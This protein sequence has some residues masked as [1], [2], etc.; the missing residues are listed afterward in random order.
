MCAVRGI[1]NRRSKWK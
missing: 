1:G